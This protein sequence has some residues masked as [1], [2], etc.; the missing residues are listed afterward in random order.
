VPKLN[1][2]R[3]IFNDAFYPYLF[4]YSHR[5]EVYRG[6]AGSGKSHFIAQ[7]IVLKALKSKRR[8]LICRRHGVTIKETVFALFKDALTGFQIIN[9]CKINNSDKTIVLPNGSTLIFKGLDDETKL[10][11]LQDISD[12]FIEEV[13]ECSKDIIEQL[14]LRMRGS[15]ENQQVFMAFNP[16]SSKHWLY[17]YCEVKPPESFFYHV[18]TYKDNKFLPEAYVKSLEDLLVRNPRKAEVFVKGN[19][20]VLLD[21]LV[22][23]NH[24]IK[25]FDI[26]ELLQNESL[27]IRC[28]M[29]MGFV[30]PTAIVTTLYD[31][32][33]G[34]IYI[35]DEFYKRGAALEEIVDAIINKMRIKKHKIYVDS[36]DPR[37]I[38][39]FSSKGIRA[40][41]A[42]KGRDSVSTGIRF[43]Q[44]HRIVC[45]TRC[46]NV[47]AELENYVYLRDKA[48]GELC[49]DKT[50]HT[51][52]HSLDALRYA[53]SDLYTSKKFRIIKTKF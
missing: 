53:Y 21:D 41:G 45:H 52:S 12:I 9:Y 49:E 37:A 43:L 22:Y 29:D 5:F 19:W 10:L 35:I 26:N 3:E 47:A 6:S 4:D 11:S 27:V 20:G 15:A 2:D 32:E 48:T 40:E 25:E 1:I 51:Y 42:R 23:P 39:Y 31:K 36:A 46:K 28:G 13:F 16:I 33:N 7:K 14:N 30:D 50:D 38:S 34:T 18:S 17:D 8:V 24:E 44:N